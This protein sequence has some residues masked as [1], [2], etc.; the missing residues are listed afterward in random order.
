M[1]VV[2][3]AVVVGASNCDNINNCACFPCSSAIDLKVFDDAGDPLDDDWTAEAAVDGVTVDDTVNCDPNA[4]FGA[5][6][7]FGAETGVYRITIRDPGH[8]TKQIAARFAAKSG[9]DCC[10][11]LPATSV[12]ATLIAEGEGEGAP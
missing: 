5:E 10:R 2:G 7:T 12:N 1:L 3:T 9:D 8:E 11:C 6:C 4:R